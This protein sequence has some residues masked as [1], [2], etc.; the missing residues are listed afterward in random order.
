ML[1]ALRVCLLCF[2]AAKTNARKKRGPN[3]VVFGILFALA[4][5]ALTA[6]RPGVPADTLE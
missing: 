6:S 5:N 4:S 3:L 2:S 1:D